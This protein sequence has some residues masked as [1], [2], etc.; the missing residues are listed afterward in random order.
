[1]ALTSSLI[2]EIGA[3]SLDIAEVVMELEQ[4]VRR[5]HS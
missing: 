4:G 1:L 2:D 5:L 3:D